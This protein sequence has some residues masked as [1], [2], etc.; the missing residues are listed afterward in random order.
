MPKTVN[1]L[2]DSQQDIVNS[3]KCPTAIKTIR[4]EQEAIFF[5]TQSLMKYTYSQADLSVQI[6]FYTK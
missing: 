6:N 4:K 3:I 5:S 1:L 2:M